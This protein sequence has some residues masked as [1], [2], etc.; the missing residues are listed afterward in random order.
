MKTGFRTLGRGLGVAGASPGLLAP[1]AAMD[2]TD[3]IA[4]GDSPLQILEQIQ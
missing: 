4:E 1:L 3:Q 2:I